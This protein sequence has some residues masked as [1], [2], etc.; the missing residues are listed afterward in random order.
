VY[1][2]NPLS[3]DDLKES[4]QY[5]LFSV[6]P[7]ELHRAVKMFLTC[8]LHMRVKGNHFGTFCTYCKSKPN[9]NCNMLF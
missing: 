1:S 2:V 7:A 3:Q 8:N 6:S 4:I 9:L 5:I